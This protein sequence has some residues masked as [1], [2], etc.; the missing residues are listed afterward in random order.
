LQTQLATREKEVSA[1]RDVTAQAR[2]RI[3][4]VL[5]RLPGATQTEEQP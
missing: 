5:E 4:A 3:D 2:Q 1:L